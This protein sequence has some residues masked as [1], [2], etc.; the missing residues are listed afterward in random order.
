MRAP[1]YVFP[2]LMDNIHIIGIMN[3]IILAFDHLLT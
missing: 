3:K 1:N 2:P